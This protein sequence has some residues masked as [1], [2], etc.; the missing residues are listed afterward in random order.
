LLCDIFLLFV[1]RYQI[2]SY[3]K[4]KILNKQIELLD[5]RIEQIKQQIQQQL[6]KEVKSEVVE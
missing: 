4:I 1:I 3:K 6:E 2:K 5:K